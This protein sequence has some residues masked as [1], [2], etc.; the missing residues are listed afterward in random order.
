MAA[1]NFSIE[2]VADALSPFGLLVRGVMNFAA[3]EPVPDG[4]AGRPARC[5]ILVGNAG[6]SLWAP[7]TSWYAAQ[8]A[9]L[10]D[11]LD[12]WSKQMIGGVAEQFKL[13]AVYPSDRPWLPFQQWAKRAEGLQASPLG[14]LMHP[15]YGLWH[16]YRGALLGDREM[17]VLTPDKL[18]HLCDACDWKPCLNSCPVGAISDGGFAVDHCRGHLKSINGIDC[19]NSGCLARNACPHD[20]FR[21]SASQQVF[22]LKAFLG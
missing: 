21:Y 2:A 4:P 15:E 6:G 1:S 11:P 9:G 13:R 20:A 18:I 22:H 3:N 16:A 5:L 17:S 12:V 8:P 14:M 10:A 19:V 7:F